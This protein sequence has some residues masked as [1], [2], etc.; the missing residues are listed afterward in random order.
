VA[1]AKTEDDEIVAA[2]SDLD[3]TVFGKQMF[4]FQRHR[5]VEHYKR[6]TSQAG[7]ILP[8]EQ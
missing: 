5:R 8:P 1:E 3:D 7:V 2:D 4:D 6:I